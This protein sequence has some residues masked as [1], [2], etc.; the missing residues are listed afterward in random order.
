MIPS[1]KF[2][3][4]IAATLALCVATGALAQN[5]GPDRHDHRDRRDYRSPQSMQHRPAPPPVV[6]ST[7]GVRPAPGYTPRYTYGQQWR[8]GDRLP[9]TYRHPTYVVNNWQTYRL[10][11]PPRGY[12]WVG[13]GA[14]FLLVAAAT[15]LIAQIIMGH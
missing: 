8:R 11:P 2:V 5:R 14:D 15:G 6:R 13:V 1:K 7:P 9:T 10:Q 4:A 3:T 12:Q